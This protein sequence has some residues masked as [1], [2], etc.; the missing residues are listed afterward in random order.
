MSRNKKI[1]V[2]GCGNLARMHA[3]CIS[4]IEGMEIAAYCDGI[5]ANA[6]SMLEEFGGS[7]AATDPDRLFADPELDGI[8]V[9]T[10]HDSHASY[11]IRALEAGK[12]VFVEKPLA[13]TTEDCIR[14]RET[15]HSTGKQLVVAFKMRYYEL[16]LKARELIPRPIMVTMQ[17]VD[18]RW[19]DGWANDPLKG[20]GNVLSQGCHSADIMRFVAGGNPVSVYAAGGNYYQPGGLIDNMAAVYRFDNGTIGNLVQGDCHCPAFASKF[21]MQLFAENKAVTIHDRFTKLIYQEAGSAHLEISGSETG[22]MEENL[23]F[24]RCLTEGV[25][26]LANEEDGLYASL[27]IL[28]A[29]ESLRSGSPQPIRDIVAMSDTGASQ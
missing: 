3:R 15:V 21:F 18:D 1:G 16:I 10:H 12:H 8:Y 13:M 5:A 20:G 19:G 23:A 9:I 27:M 2:L 6:R 11:S 26:T 17:M 7:Y 22:F 25:N 29:F 4:Q 24:Y 28:Q 14:V